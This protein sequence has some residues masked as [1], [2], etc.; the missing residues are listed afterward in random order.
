MPVLA[1]RMTCSMDQSEWQKHMLILWDH[2]YMRGIAK[3]HRENVV[4]WWRLGSQT[5]MDGLKTEYMAS[6][7]V[8]GVFSSGQESR[9]NGEADIAVGC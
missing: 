3:P 6:K 8:L 4:G 7:A 2:A 9:L 5:E 1:H